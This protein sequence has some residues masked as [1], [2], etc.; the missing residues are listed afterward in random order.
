MTI[1]I[2][3]VFYS[4]GSTG[5]QVEITAEN[6]SVTVMTKATHDEMIEKA[7]NVNLS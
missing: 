5:E 3:E 4:D 7:A 1:E 2:R 6:G